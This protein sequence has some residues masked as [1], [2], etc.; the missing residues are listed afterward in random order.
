[1]WVMDKKKRDKKKRDRKKQDSTTHTKIEEDG[2]IMKATATARARGIQIGARRQ[3]WDPLSEVGA[4]DR[5]ERERRGWARC[6]MRA[7][8]QW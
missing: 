4:E 8:E 5:A 2:C 6:L 7:C 1:M 3:V